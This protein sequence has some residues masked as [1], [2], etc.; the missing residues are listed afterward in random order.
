LEKFKAKLEI[1]GVNPFVFVPAKVLNKLFKQSG[2]DKGAIPV[3]GTVNDKPYK[4]TL[5]RYKAHW[6]LYINTT[7]L[8][9]SPKRVGEMLTIEVEF[10]PTDRTIK[11]HPDLTK[12]LKGNKQAKAV[13]DKLSP[14]RQKEIVRYISFLKT[15]ESRARNITRML[16]F[17]MGKERF[18]GRDKP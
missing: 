4:Q 9:Q 7:M 11:P 6:R 12:A 8:K 1:I 13:F 5:L 14:S 16:N 15:D 17:L 2:K 18:V 3:H 10:D